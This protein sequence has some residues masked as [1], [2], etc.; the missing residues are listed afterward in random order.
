MYPYFLNVDEIIEEM[1]RI[2]NYVLIVITSVALVSCFGDD[3]ESQFEVLTD[4]Y[5]LKKKSGDEEVYARAFY[6]YANQLINSA[7]ATE[8]GGAGEKITLTQDPRSVYTYS[9]IPQVS[10]FNP[11]PPAT[12]DYLFQVTSEGG[13]IKESQDFLSFDDIDIPDITKV[14][15]AEIDKYLDVAWTEVDGADGYLLK[16]LNEEGTEIIDGYGFSTDILEYR[17]NILLENWFETPE[18][19]KTYIVEVHAYVYEPQVEPGYEAYNVQE[20]SVSDAEIIWP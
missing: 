5:V 11:Y 9:K 16:I 6:A 1:R 8:I 17:L 12:S 20:V 14:E 4:A 10:D 15:F 18:Q 13:I 2:T 7:T 3:T 19:G